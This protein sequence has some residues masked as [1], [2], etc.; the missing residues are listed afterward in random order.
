[1][2][3]SSHDGLQQGDIVFPAVLHHISRP[4]AG[5][6]LADVGFAQVKHAQPRLTDPTTNGL[7]QLIIEQA[8][9]KVQILAS[10][11]TPQR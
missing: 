1:M 7:G 3:W 10:Q 2:V 11:G 5:L 9:V 6:D 8:L 4:Y